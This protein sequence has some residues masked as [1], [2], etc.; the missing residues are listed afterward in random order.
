MKYLSVFLIFIMLFSCKKEDENLDL[1]YEVLNHIISN[2]ENNL[3]KN[4]GMN[5]VYNIKVIKVSFPENKQI[6]NNLE[7]QPTG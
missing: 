5:H 3:D 6:E 7:K 4:N 2:E 1:K